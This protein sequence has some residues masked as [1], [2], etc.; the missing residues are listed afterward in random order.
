MKSH[1]KS[2]PILLVLAVLL[3]IS[4]GISALSNEAQASPSGSKPQTNT[5]LPVDKIDLVSQLGGSIIDADIQGGYAYVGV[6]PCLVTLKLLN[7]AL[8]VVT[9][10]T[11]VL[12]NLVRRVVVSGGYVYVI[13]SPG[14]DQE[15]YS[16]RVFNLADPA[17]PVESGHFN[18]P[19][20]WIDLT[21]AGTTAYVVEWE[22][23]R[24][25]DVTNP[26]NPTSASYFELESGTSVAVQGDYAFVAVCCSDPSITVLNITNSS[27]PTF[28][29]RTVMSGQPEDMDV[30]G[31]YIYLTETDFGLRIYDISNPA[32]PTAVGL[33]EIPGVPWQ[34]ASTAIVGN[35]AYFA[36]GDRLRILDIS[37]PVNPTEASSIQRGGQDVDVAGG[38]AI[39]NDGWANLHIL[40]I[41]NPVNPIY[42][43]TFSSP[44]VR[45]QDVALTGNYVYAADL[46]AGLRIF[47]IANPAN[48]TEAG[49]F[50]METTYGTHAVTLAGTYAYL[51]EGN[52]VRIVD[53]ANPM[54]P[55]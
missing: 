22:G 11:E 33:Y 55:C 50:N 15:G 53:V 40:N 9:G 37:D 45:A 2:L 35:Y 6:G 21:I 38:L 1:S 52:G 29:G 28:V 16:L 32:N 49:F 44:L 26:A 7:P 51:A 18:S 34:V 41:N 25:L 5:L 3:L 47:D 23:I 8:P 48:P 10:Q 4:V 20:G 13:I 12:P 36:E 17:N 54:T 43:S 27:N 30:T 46:G 31:H 19:G 14:F 42:K 24:I 39:V